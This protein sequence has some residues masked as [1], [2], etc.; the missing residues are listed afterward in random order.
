MFSFFKYTFKMWLSLPQT[1]QLT[2]KKIS[3]SK[4]WGLDVPDLRTSELG[5]WRELSS[6]L[7]MAPFLASSHGGR[8]SQPARPF[9]QGPNPTRGA[10]PS[11][12]VHLPK[13]PPWRSGPQCAN[14]GE[15][16]TFSPRQRVNM[17]SVYMQ[18]F[19]SLF[20][21]P[22]MCILFEGKPS[23]VPVVPG[24]C[25]HPLTSPSPSALPFHS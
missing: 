1:G 21:L 13:A 6:G 9:S 8:A 18:G 20:L 14:L 22:T 15:M 10:P 2:N 24:A 16:K 12:P 4:F 3:F 25:Q 23:E 17:H 19:Y 7:Q 5:L 11:R